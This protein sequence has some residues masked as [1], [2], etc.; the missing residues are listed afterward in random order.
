MSRSP[1]R[2]AKREVRWDILIIL[3]CLAIAALMAANG[4]GSGLPG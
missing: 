3:A 1:Y 4:Y 2:H